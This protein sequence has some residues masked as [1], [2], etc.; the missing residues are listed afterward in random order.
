M[1]M[2]ERDMD[3]RM[4]RPGLVEVGQHVTMT[5][6]ILKTLSGTMYYYTINDAVAMSNNTPKRLSHLEGTV[7]A[8]VEEESVFTVT[9]T[10]ADEPEGR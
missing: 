7:K 10:I 5:E 1:E 8:V 2:A 9:V 3:F 6:S 4:E